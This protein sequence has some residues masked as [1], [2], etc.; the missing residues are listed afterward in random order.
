MLPKKPLPYIQKII[1]TFIVLAL[2]GGAVQAGR[3]FTGPKGKFI[4][5]K[6]VSARSKGSP[7]A[8]LWIVEYIDFQCG[9]CSRVSGILREYLEKYPS[10]IYLQVRFRPLVLTH[11]FALKSAVY[12]ECPASQGKF[13]PFYEILFT[14]QNDWASSDF[15]DDLF[16]SY[17][18]EIGM[19][20]KKLDICIQDEAVKKKVIAENDEAIDLG[21]KSTPT[22]FMN[23]KMV[24]GLDALKEELEAVFPEKKE[25]VS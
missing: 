25:V 1:A 17:A 15:P 14:R 16:H 24:V 6:R 18:K 10:Q 13:W 2:C 9:A 22:F 20:V 11:P 21:V 19:N 4:V 23:G 3:Y 12:A 8:S 7:K 5:D